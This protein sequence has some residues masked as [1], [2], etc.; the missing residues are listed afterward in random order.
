MGPGLATRRSFA[1]DGEQ[2]P[3]PP[4]DIAWLRGHIIRGG[5]TQSYIA[6]VATCVINGETGL[7]C[8]LLGSVKF[9]KLRLLRST[10]QIGRPLV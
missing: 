8:G 6:R 5:Q 3:P 1:T 4:T 10:L 7:A 2:P 9:R